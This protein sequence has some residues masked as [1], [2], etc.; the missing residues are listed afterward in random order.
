MSASTPYN[1]VFPESFDGKGLTNENSLAAARLTE[2]DYINQT[3]TFLQGKDSDAFPLTFLTEGQ[4]KG[5]NYKETDD[6][7]YKWRIMGKLDQADVV[8]GSSYVL[9]SK[10]GLAK[11]DI[12]VTFK[13]NY[14]KK[15][16][17]IVAADG[18]QCRIVG[19][20]SPVSGGYLY[21]LRVL[22]PDRSAYVN[23]IL[24]QAG[25]LWAHQG[26]GTVS[27]SLS[28]GNESNIVTPGEVKN[29]MSVLRKSFHIGGNIG[30]RPVIVKFPKKGGGTTNLWMDFEEWRHELI[31][32][33]HCEEHLWT[34]KYNRDANGVI[35]DLDEETGLPI[36]IGSGVLDQIPNYDT[37]STLTVDKLDS[38]VLSVMYGRQDDWSPKEIVLYT[39]TGGGREFDRAIKAALPGISQITGDKFVRGSGYGLVYGGYFTAYETVEGLRITVKKLNILDAGGQAMTAPKHPSGLPVTSYNMYFVDQTT[40]DGVPNVQM[41]TQRNR[42]LIRGIEQGMALYKGSS[43][44]DYAG[45]AN[46]LALSTSQDKTSIHYLATKGIVINNNSHCF[47]LEMDYSIGN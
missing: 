8:V 14:L 45:N 43:Y 42:S 34:S 20:P 40:Y 13:S 25:A 46:T 38:T 24:L 30:N 2:P 3:L 18:T 28:F 22:G 36:P 12:K 1:V 21:T 31:W 5:V 29:Q 15:Q 39:G 9:A 44:G 6:I 35:L 33:K 11:T 17:T 37:Y 32:K 26:P 10:P 16:H 19:T 7:Q 47:A 23:P 4:K 41:V 27:E